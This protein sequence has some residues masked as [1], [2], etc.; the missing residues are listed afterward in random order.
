MSKT[1]EVE[2]LVGTVYRVTI[3]A[4]NMEAALA[5]ANDITGDEPGVEEVEADRTVILEHSHGRTAF[6][7]GIE[8]AVLGA[9]S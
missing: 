8:A 4:E 7:F 5:A 1:Y 6:G 2:V 3:E 9:R